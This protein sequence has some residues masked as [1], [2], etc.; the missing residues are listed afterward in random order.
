MSCGNT[1]HLRCNSNARVRTS[2]LAARRFC[3]G[4]LI[5]GAPI[6]G[7]KISRVYN[8]ERNANASVSSKNELSPLWLIDYKAE[9]KQVKEMKFFHGS[10][11]QRIFFFDRIFSLSDIKSRTCTYVY[12]RARV[13][14]LQPEIFTH[15]GIS[16]HSACYT[17]ISFLIFNIL[18]LLYFSNS[19][20]LKIF[21]TDLKDIHHRY[22]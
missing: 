19:I 3:L 4:F 20:Y 11:S 5:N 2:S 6:M 14:L 22:K 13:A 1:I 17:Y 8:G 16:S 7:C 15:S 18:Y 9:R 10:M 21:T 12:R